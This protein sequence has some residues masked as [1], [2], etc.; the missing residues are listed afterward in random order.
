MLLSYLLVEVSLYFSCMVSLFI[1]YYNN[2]CTRGG[3]RQCLSDTSHFFPIYPFSYAMFG[4]KEME[5]KEG[6]GNEYMDFP[7]LD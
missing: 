3:K 2:Y 6:K 5:G 7:H 4:L 1:K